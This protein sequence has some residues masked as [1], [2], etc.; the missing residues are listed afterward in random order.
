[1]S[2]IEVRP[3]ERVTWH[4]KKGKES[5][6]RP[7]TIMALVNARTGKYDTGLDYSEPFKAPDNTDALT[8]AQYY[9]K[10][11]GQDLSNTYIPGKPHSYWDNP[12]SAIKLENKTMIFDTSNPIDYIKVKVMKASKY[13]ANSM[14]EYNEGKYPSATHVISDEKEEVEIKAARVEVKKSAT[15]EASKLS[16]ERKVQLIHIVGGKNLKGKS[17]DFIEVEMDNLI[18]NNARELLYWIKADKKIVKI[19]S[20]VMEALKKNVIRSI[21]GKLK[22]REIELGF[23]IDEATDFLSQDINNELLIR[24]EQEISK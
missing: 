13:V 21:G 3:I 14:R 5:F 22:Y 6:K 16:K 4:G 15:I 10:L 23:D 18:E 17:D 1:M 11:I 24:V 12:I 8:E 9:G 2:K 20:E 19:K 7:V